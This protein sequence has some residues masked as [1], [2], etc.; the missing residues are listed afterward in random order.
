MQSQLPSPSPFI[1][2]LIV[3]CLLLTAKSLP[4]L[5]YAAAAT[6]TAWMIEA[7]YASWSGSETFIIQTISFK[8]RAYRWEIG[9]RSTVE[10]E[11]YVSMSWLFCLW[12]GL[13]TRLKGRW[14]HTSLGLSV[15]HFFAAYG[16]CLSRSETKKVVCMLCC[17]LIPQNSRK[18]Q[19]STSLHMRRGVEIWG[20]IHRAPLTLASRRNHF[21]S[22]NWL[23]NAWR[24]R[25][26]ET[27]PLCYLARYL[28]GY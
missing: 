15:C 11:G 1:Q 22:L 13:Q 2:L 7:W 20:T 27:L 26:N 3:E 14:K 5:K 21:S 16:G 12:T 9:C 4:L 17:W 18:K 25:N 6:A 28:T 10:D 19:D 24:R 23:S 8:M